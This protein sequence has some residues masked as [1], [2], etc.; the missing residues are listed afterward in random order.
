MLALHIL[1]FLPIEDLLAG[2]ILYLNLTRPYNITFITQQLS[3]FLTKP[4]T[5]HHNAALRV[6]KYLKDS[7][8]RG[9]FFPRDSSIQLI[10]FSNA[11]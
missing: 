3:Q 1:T 9:L 5:T 8:E 6:L 7:L 4:T 11:D 2:L 10:G